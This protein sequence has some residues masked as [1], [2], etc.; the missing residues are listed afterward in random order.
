MPKSWIPLHW[1]YESHSFISGWMRLIITS[2]KEV[3]DLM[4]K[5]GSDYRAS[6][7]VIGNQNAIGELKGALIKLSKYRKVV[8]VF[9]S[10]VHKELE[11]T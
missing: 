8:G 1:S 2:S 7:K 5:T 6:S 11:R 10:H 9:A 4:S 3:L